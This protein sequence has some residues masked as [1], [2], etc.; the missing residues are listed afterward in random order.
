MDHAGRSEPRPG[1][2]ERKKE[3]TRRAIASAALRLFAERGY[4]ET[5]IADIAAAAEVS[6]RTFFGYFPSKEDVV[7]AEIDDRLAEVRERLARRVPDETPLE[8]VRR[9]AADAIAALAAEHGDYGAVQI[10][11]ILE[12]P[13]LQ[14]RALQR[15]TDTQ[16]ELGA[17][18]AGL[19]P[20]LDEI[21]ALAAAG[22]AVG[23]VQTVIM[24]CRRHGFD[25][26]AIRAALD[27]A[28][29]VVEHGLRSV[30]ALSRPAG[31]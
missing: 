13:G 1:L 9:A 21:D 3:R 14:A 23:A 15:L 7:F 2:R 8:T 26:A 30:E 25:P 20:D 28:L 19:C 24:H 11:L 27:R 31:P 4:E 10:R 22:A 29:D 17:L 18:L 5:T 6:P 12:R 16:Q